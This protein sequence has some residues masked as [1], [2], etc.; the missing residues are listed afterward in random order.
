MSSQ[1][2]ANLLDQIDNLKAANAAL[3]VSKGK[4]PSNPYVIDNSVPFATL[5]CSEAFE[6]LT[7]KERLYAYHICQVHQCLCFMFA[8]EWYAVCLYGLP[9]HISQWLGAKIATKQI[10]VITPMF[11]GLLGRSQ[12]CASSDFLRVSHYLHADP[13]GVLWP[14]PGGA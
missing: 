6:G 3:R 2:I 7:E 1:I 5:N 12:D 13:A 14:T 11:T 4:S 10:N 8:C 9:M